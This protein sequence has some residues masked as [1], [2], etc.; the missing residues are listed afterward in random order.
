MR[1]QQVTVTEVITKALVDEVGLNK[2]L[3]IL[4]RAIEKDAVNHPGNRNPD[5]IGMVAFAKIYAENA[6]ICLCGDL[7]NEKCPEHGNKNEGS[8]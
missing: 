4:N 2:T 3:R 6:D 7:V 8:N 5:F 1:Q